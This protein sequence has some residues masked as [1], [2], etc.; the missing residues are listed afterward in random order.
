MRKNKGIVF[1]TIFFTTFLVFNLVNIKEL[2]YNLLFSTE[3]LIISMILYS[4]IKDENAYFDCVVIVFFLLFF[5]V[6]PIIQISNNKLP[7]TMMLKLGLILKSI[8]LTNIFLLTYYLLRFKIKIKFKVRNKGYKKEYY[9]FR[10]F[11]TTTFILYIIFFIVLIP[12]LPKLLNSLTGNVYISQVVDE[13]GRIKELIIKSCL[14]LIPLFISTYN[15]YLSKIKKFKWINCI[16]ALLLLLL[17]K[18]FF[19]ENR[20]T[21]A[22]IYLSILVYL[23][24]DKLDMRKLTILLIGIFIF[25]YPVVEQIVH[26]NIRLIDFF[27]GTQSFKSLFEINYFDHFLKLDYDAWSNFLATIEY[28]QVYGFSYGL[29]LLGSLLFFVPRV[30]WPLKPIATGETVGRYLM[31]TTGM[32]FY[33]LSNPLISEGYIDFGIIGVVLYGAILGIVSK[34]IRNMSRSNSYV[35]FVAIFISMQMF[36]FLRGD[37][38]SSISFLIASI[39]GVYLLPIFVDKV[40]RV[41]RIRKV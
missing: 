25:A 28:T 23:I 4:V 19:V 36:L 16:I 7:N 13:S 18:N 24:K 14:F 22:P 17:V 11:K 15:I 3:I 39:I 34:E 9:E 10:F 5:Y 38:L 40:L 29:Q 37:M 1:I 41:I 2:H 32:W 21:I 33:N 8:M 31:A 27:D 6:A 30:M 20:G 26:S 35:S 12:Q